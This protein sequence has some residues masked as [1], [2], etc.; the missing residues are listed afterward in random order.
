[1]RTSRYLLAGLAAALLV[2]LSGCATPTTTTADRHDHNRD[3]KQGAAYTSS[4]STE[5][6][7][8]LHDH[9]EWK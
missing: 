1:M 6:V 5:P 8:P 4:G 9:H 3:N 7:K 2:G